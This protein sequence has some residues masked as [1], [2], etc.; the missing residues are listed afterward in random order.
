MRQFCEKLQKFRFLRINLFREKILNFREKK[1]KIFSLVVILYDLYFFQ[2]CQIQNGT[3][4]TLICS[5]IWKIKSF[6]LEKSSF[7]I[8]SALFMRKAMRKLLK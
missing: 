5:T 1:S 2:A 4:N 6:L 7:L 8:N 3:F